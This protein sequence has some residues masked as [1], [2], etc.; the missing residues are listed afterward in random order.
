MI[1]HGGSAV[2]PGCAGCAGEERKN[3]K[4]GSLVGQLLAIGAQHGGVGRRGLQATF[5]HVANHWF[6][7]DFSN[8]FSRQA[9][10]IQPGGDSENYGEGLIHWI[11]LIG[12]GESANQGF[13]DENI[14]VMGVRSGF[15]AGS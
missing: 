2:T 10:G 1:R 5:Q 15:R 14:S 4:I 3:P 9:A 8:Q 13:L 12:F 6:A 11:V 7:T